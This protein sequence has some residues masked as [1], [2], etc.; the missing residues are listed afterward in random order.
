MRAKGVFRV[1]A[2][3][4]WPSD[5]R[6]KEIMDE[7]K[8]GQ[9]VLVHLHR[10]RWPEHHRLAFAVFSKIAEA[11]GVPVDT[12][13][14]WLK[15]ELGWVDIVRLPNGKHIPSPRSIAWE[16]MSQDE[17]ATWWREAWVVLSEKIMP[18]LP[19]E[20]FEE[21]RAIVQPAGCTDQANLR[22]EPFLCSGVPPPRRSAK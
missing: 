7:L 12:I 18:G 14:L 2:G 11:K 15:W 9:H 8:T 4:L 16:S 21:I 19:A 10:A 13:V 20:L 6:A 5:A 1:V 3:Q 17:F 22:A